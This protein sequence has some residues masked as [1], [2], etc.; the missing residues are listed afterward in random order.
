MV[1]DLL[2]NIYICRT[3]YNNGAWYR[4]TV[5]RNGVNATLSVKPLS[6][7]SSAQSE[8]KTEYIGLTELPEGIT[9]VF[10]AAS[11]ERYF[12]KFHLVIIVNPRMYRPK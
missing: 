5:S 8:S 7:T 6:E 9:I 10:G 4:V 11:G 1:S 12:S 2:N 3:T